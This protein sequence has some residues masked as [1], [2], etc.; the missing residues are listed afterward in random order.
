MIF[1]HQKKKKA[2][3]IFAGIGGGTKGF[4]LADVNYKGVWGGFETIGA[5]DASPL[6]VKN[7]QK[8]IGKE[9]TQLDLFS[10]SQYIKFHGHQ[11][12]EGWTEATPYDVWRA[13]G[14]EYP[15][16]VFASPPC[17]GFSGLL[18]ANKVKTD[19]YQALNELTVR[20]IK[21]VLQAFEEDL[22]AFILLENVPRIKDRGVH[23][24]REITKLLQAHGYAIDGQDHDCGPIGGLAQHR[25]RYLLI[26]RNTR[27]VTP[28]LY[29]PPKR[30]M[31][32]VG[33]VLVNLPMPGDLAGG[34]MH[35]L[36]NH[37]LK[38]WLRLALIEAGN[39]WRQLQEIDYSRYVLTDEH[40]EPWEIPDLST[41]FKPG[42]HATIY[43]V[44][45]WDK[46][47]NTV[48]GA[49]RTNNGAICIADPRLNCKPRA[50]L[51]KITP[52]NRPT[53]TVTG[54]KGIHSGALAVADP[55]VID[56]KQKGVW[57]IISEDGT[58][59]RPLTTLEL[60][61]LQ[62]FP[63]V[64]NRKPLELEG[65]E[66]DWREQIG[67]AVPVQA[68]QAIAETILVTLMAADEGDW[69]M[70]AEEIWVRSEREER[71]LMVQ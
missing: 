54:A 2:F 38:T 48:T 71:P 32:S 11:P 21:L 68:A 13:A 19:K 58:W 27:K 15:D 69:I 31:K 9:A 7:Y 30:K 50:G 33:D 44:S 46:P 37:E 5:I 28:L 65:R 70:S 10:T 22:P 6:V 56:I 17:K 16:V 8:I 41:K 40:G 49:Y 20:S 39:D 12:P 66:A 18:G 51:Y 4:E 42:T 23:L 63:T 26:A 1:K 53:N 64:V 67:N 34:K 60:A 24:L 45:R 62:G 61:A 59:H 47:C 29:Q 35:Q 57:T 3:F 36:P 43:R 55:R 52:W 14:G 25:N